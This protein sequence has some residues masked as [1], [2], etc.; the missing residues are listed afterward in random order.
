MDYKLVAID[1]DGTLLTPDLE[2]SKQTIETTRE[3]IAKGVMIIL[4][5]GRMYMAALPF[6]ER[7]QLDVPLIT[8]N[9]ALIKCAKTKKEFYKKIITKKHY[10]AITN[11]CKKH[12]LSI[13]VYKDDSIFIK[14]KKN[15]PIHKQIDKAEPETVDDLNSIYDHSVIKLLISSDNSY[16]LKLHINELYN[17]YKEK[18]TFYFSFPHFVE[19]V[20][21]EANKRNALEFLANKYNI[22]QEEIIAIGDNFNDLD[23]I[24]YAGLGIAMGNAPHY[25][26]EAAD[27]VTHSNDDDG[28]NYILEKFILK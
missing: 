15:L 11:F 5:T 7:L 17:L 24:E 1:M 26:K 12:Q 16:L 18:L 6:A 4:S 27:F 20:N 2:I 22:R 25:L 3:V 10:E 8:C 9:G 28:V 13:S 14:D 19:I 23:M 21:K